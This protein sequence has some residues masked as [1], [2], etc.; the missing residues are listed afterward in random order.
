VWYRVA[1]I[2]NLD[3]DTYDIMVNGVTKKQG[4]DLFTD[5]TDIGLLISQAGCQDDLSGIAIWTDDVLV[6]N[7]VPSPSITVTSPNGGESWVCG[8]YHAITWTNAYSSGTTVRIELWRGGLG[9]PIPPTLVQTLAS[10]ETNDGSYSWTISTSLTPATDYRIRISSTTT[11]ATDGSDAFFTITGI[12]T[13][14]V[15]DPNGGEVWNLGSYHLITWTSAN[16]PGSYVRIEL[17]KSSTLVS[18]LTSSVSNTGS[19]GWTIS[20]TLK[21]GTDYRV[22]VSST[23]TSASDFSD[24]YFTLEKVSDGGGGGGGGPPDGPKLEAEISSTAFEPAEELLVWTPFV[25][26]ADS[27]NTASCDVVTIHQ[28]AVPSE[29]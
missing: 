28:E 19:Y 25:V 2:V 24:A 1:L 17:Y 26:A 15:T 5:V 21:K 16:N 20:A 14:T 10:T 9:L 7:V 13:I 3:T 6:T 29:S 12:P 8:S 23:T 18:T 11:A 27:L 22:K 4:I